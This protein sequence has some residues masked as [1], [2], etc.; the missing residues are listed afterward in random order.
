MSH[1]YSDMH[2][3]SPFGPN[4]SNT[5]PYPMSKSNDVGLT[6]AMASGK[7]AGE[8]YP[9]LVDVKSARVDGLANE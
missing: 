2:Q 8:E 9:V 7:A 4:R 6:K 5:L 1:I 3:Y